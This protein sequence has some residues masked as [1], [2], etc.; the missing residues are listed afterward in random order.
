MTGKIYEIMIIDF[1]QHF[2][3]EVKS[4]YL[5]I[6]I[7]MLVECRGVFR[8]NTIYH[9]VEVVGILFKGIVIGIGTKD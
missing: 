1:F 2:L 4:A 7:A 6:N 3:W 9:S 8:K 5:H